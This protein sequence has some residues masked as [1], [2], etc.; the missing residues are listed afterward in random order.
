LEGLRIRQAKVTRLIDFALDNP[1]DTEADLDESKRRLKQH[2]TERSQIAAEIARLEEIKDR[3]RRVPTENDLHAILGQLHGILIEAANAKTPDAG[4]I[5]RLLELLTAG[6]MVVEQ[7]GERRH[8][9]GWLRVHVPI[10]LLAVCADRL[11]LP[12][13]CRNEAER[14]IV[15]D[16]KGETI[17]EKY[18]EQIMQMYGTGMLVTAIAEKLGIER[19]QVTE[20]I[21][22]WHERNGM[23]PPLD[24]RVRRASVPDKLLRPPVFQVIAEEA[25]Q[26]LDQGLLIEEIAER[27]GRTRDTVRVAL[28]FW[29]EAHGQPMPDFRHRR[30]ELQIKNRPKSED[31]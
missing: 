29:F 11:E 22:I 21:Q 15:V 20:A 10:R 16:I 2:R 31:A 12:P 1:G 3:P 9:R 23:P 27:L 8:C 14:G 5:R 30:K 17:A 18:M 25:K 13:L 28:R 24:G 6:R 4:A 7:M 19:H 26:L